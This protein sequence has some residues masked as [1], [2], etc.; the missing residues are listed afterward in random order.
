MSPC[1][2]LR[3]VHRPRPSAI[4]HR[5]Q[6]SWREEKT[7]RVWYERNAGVRVNVKRRVWEIVETAEGHDLTSRMADVFIVTLIIG[8]VATVMLES[9]PGVLAEYSEVLWRFE[10][11][12]VGVFSI[13]YLLRLW[14]CTADPHYSHPVK[15]RVRFATSPLALI[16]FIA[17]APFY[18]P[19][20]LP[21]G[22]LFLRV[23]RLVRLFRL[24]KFG[25]YSDAPGLVV[26]A[27][28]RRRQE[29]VAA[30][31][32]LFLLLISMASLLYLAESPHRPEVYSSIPVTMWW[33]V[34]A[35][36]GN[37]QVAPITLAG[38]LI[39][40][41]IAIIGVGL[42]ALPAGLL[43]SAFN[44]ELTEDK[45]D[46]G[47]GDPDIERVT[48]RVALAHA[49]KRSE[50]FDPGIVMEDYAESALILTPDAV[51]KGRGGGEQ[52][53]RYMNE[54]SQATWVLD[55][56]SVA[57]E[58]ALLHWVS[59]AQAV[60]SPGEGRQRAH[61]AHGAAQAAERH[62]DA[63]Q[64]GPRLEAAETIV[65]RDGLIRVQSIDIVVFDGRTG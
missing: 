15:G 12:A 22:L 14:S 63:E 45:P 48:A 7:G 55:R 8:S 27:V 50:R 53:K 10:L 28:R 20:L 23:L 40:S 39:A 1:P 41:A 52:L 32:V 58:V 3:G 59:R 34:L 2:V 49:E 62:G 6:R 25:R 9:V 18:L 21:S 54:K 11:F 5:A 65:V 46:S 29:L 56:Y 61:G 31:F 51:F 30:M 19:W 33:S 57:G 13:E 4:R 38:R 36:T 64:S 37:G 42:F 43:A 47:A 24:Y 17:I 26:R 16:D 44:E 35:L 60:G